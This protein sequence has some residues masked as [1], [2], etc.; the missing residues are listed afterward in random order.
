MMKP[1]GINED[2]QGLLEILEDIIGSNRHVAGMRALEEGVEHC[3]E[4]RLEHTN[5]V[6]ASLIELRNLEDAR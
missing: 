6:K 5:R 3:N 1:K 4:E 2:D